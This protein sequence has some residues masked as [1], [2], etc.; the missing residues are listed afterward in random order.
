MPSPFPGMNP[1]LEQDDVW[2]DFHDSMIPAMRD[3]LVGQAGSDYVVKIEQQLYIHEPPMDHRLLI[4]KGDVGFSTAHS[5]Q[6]T[7]GAATA[8]R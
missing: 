7:A 3:A 2:Q 6:E 1:Y 5:G 8:I 4:G